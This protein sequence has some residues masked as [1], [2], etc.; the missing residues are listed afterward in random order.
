MLKFRFV[1]IFVL[2]LTT[3]LATGALAED[4][5]AL[6]VE[7]QTVTGLPPGQTVDSIATPSANR[8]GGWAFNFNATDGVTTISTIWGNATNG[9][10][11]VIRT[12]GTF[13]PYE[14]TSF[15]SF[16][17]FGGGGVSS[18]SPSCDNTESGSTGLD[19]VWLDDVPIAVEENEFPHQVGYWWRF[20]SR[21]GV[22]EDG[23]PYFVGG[24]T[25]TQGGGTDVRGLFYGLDAAPVFLGGD[26]LPGLPVPL[27]ASASPGFD[28][29]FSVY[30]THFLCEVDLDTGGSTDDGAMV[31]DGAGL[32][33]DGQLVQEATPVPASVGGWPDENW[34]NFDYVGVSE[35]GGYMITGDTDA[36]TAIDE[37]VLLDGVFVLREGDMINGY[38]LS[39]GIQSGFMN[40]DGDFAVVWDV[41]LPTGENVEVLIFNGQ[42]V[43]KEGDF[44]DTDGDGLPNADSFVTDFT[45]IAALVVTDREDDNSVRI[46]FTADVSTPDALPA[47]TGQA[48]PPNEAAGRDD[49]IEAEDTDEVVIEIGYC[50]TFGGAV[51]AMLSEFLCDPQA[52][53]V[54]ISWRLVGDLADASFILRADNGERTWD[55]PFTRE[56]DGL[57]K[58]L[59]TAAAGEVVTYTLL[60]ADADGHEIVTGEQN[61][62]PV[63]PM[64][65][66]VLKGAHPNPFNPSTKV[67]FRVGATQHVELKVYDMSGRLVGVLADQVFP[68]GDHQVS[69]NGRDLHGSRVPSGTYMARVVSDRSVKT[70]K[71]MLVK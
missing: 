39:G 5:T 44:I 13:P 35:D 60:I 24:L 48:L 38:T 7:G 18:Y 36:D 17:G 62:R 61:V 55:V 6:I 15:E 68:A 53:G 59:D 40:E 14:Q 58:A 32:E 56:A 57:F 46:Y 54:H 25:E 8:D 29:R 67:S 52:D 63:M 43:L 37:F 19:G 21:P 12:E 1:F 2:S 47:P 69:W 27:T 66:L 11:N 4:P 20:G 34:D 31:F 41:D 49:P 9:P 70:V 45:G 71:L 22:T 42:V 30:G 33:I 3:L 50:L 65:T 51:P 23:I 28:F 10:G 64:R 26:S 16:W